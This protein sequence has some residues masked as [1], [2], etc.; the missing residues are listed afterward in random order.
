MQISER[1]YN[2]IMRIDDL[3]KR[4]A[5]LQEFCLSIGWHGDV[6][7]KAMNEIDKLNKL[8]IKTALEKS[9]LSGKI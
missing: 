1:N 7:N 2:R 5:K 4:K 3:S 6:W 8:G 9:L